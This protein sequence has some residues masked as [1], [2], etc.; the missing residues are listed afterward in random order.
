MAG[1]PVARDDSAATAADTA[2]V[3]DVLANDNDGDG[4]TAALA[5]V[6]ESTTDPANGSV[7]LNTGGDEGDR[8]LHPEC[9]LPGHGQLH[10]HGREHEDEHP[11]PRP[12]SR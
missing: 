9:G 11:K 10:L 4:G 6:D 2:V 1:T 7:G 5:I 3:I 12:P 8:N